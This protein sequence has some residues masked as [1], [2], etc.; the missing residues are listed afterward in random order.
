MELVRARLTQHE[1]QCEYREVA[2]PHQELG[3]RVRRVSRMMSAHQAS[4]KYRPVNCPLPAC[5]AQVPHC[6]LMAHLSCEHNVRQ[7]SPSPLPQ[8]FSLNSLLMIFLVLSLATNLSLLY[9]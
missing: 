9:F 4:C 1:A 3:C 6:H 8:L 7:D 2:C 5:R